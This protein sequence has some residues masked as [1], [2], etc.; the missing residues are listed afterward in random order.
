VELVGALDP[1]PLHMIVAQ[2]LHVLIFMSALCWLRVF[3]VCVCGVSS[4]SAVAAALSTNLQ[5]GLSR[6]ESVVRLKAGG[7]NAV[8]APVKSFGSVLVHELSE[9]LM[10]LLMFVGVMFLCFGQ[11]TEAISG[12]VWSALVWGEDVSV[13]LVCSIDRYVCVVCGVWCCVAA[14]C[15]I[16]LTILIEV[17]V[18]L[19]AKRAVDALTYGPP[20][21][22]RCT[23]P[24]LN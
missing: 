4:V 1:H 19:N 8:V 3:C 14:L 16:L 20:T 2:R 9:P 22:L 13:S 11:W 18:E 17:M 21:P 5:T 23:R 7:P 15:I 12:Q 24:E 10:L 6:A